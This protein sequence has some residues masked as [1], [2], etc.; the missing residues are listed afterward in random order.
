VASPKTSARAIAREEPSTRGDDSRVD[1]DRG[2]VP[3]KGP[4]HAGVTPERLSR[5]DTWREE[6]RTC[7]GNSTP[8]RQERLSV[9]SPARAG[10]TRSVRRCA[11]RPAMEPR[12]RGGGSV[13]SFAAGHPA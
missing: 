7:G 3:C 12:T 1:R 2:P 11:Q 9:E 13:L 10:V 6:S 5:S 4:A 8:N